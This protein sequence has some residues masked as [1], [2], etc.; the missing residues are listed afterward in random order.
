[1]RSLTI[2]KTSV[3]VLILLLAPTAQAELEIIPLRH[4]TVDQ[5][6]PVLRPL[7]EPGG[8]LSGQNNQLIVR[9]SPRNLEEIRRVLASID[10]PQRRLMISV[11]FDANAQAR[12]RSIDARGTVRSGNVTITNQPLPTAQSSVSISARAN[13][14]TASERVDQRIQV[15]DGGHA[16]I[17]TG[18][19]RPI[20][21]GIVTVTPS[22]RTITQ[23]TEIQSAQTGFDVV[24]RVSGTQVFLDIAP[25]RETFGDSGARGRAS[26][27]H[28]QRAATT[29]SARLGA[30]FEIG[31]VAQTASGSTGGIG[32]SRETSASSGRRIWVRVDEVRP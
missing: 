26:T 15:L 7:L 13:Q 20:R 29:V 22:G 19:S 6:L 17:S 27:V 25:Q 12:D 10:S 23:G 30:W 16:F 5:V 24:P 1:M 28:S 11:R 32:S 21:Q 14:S 18:E 31:G 8:V 4:R 9:T 2:I 3:F